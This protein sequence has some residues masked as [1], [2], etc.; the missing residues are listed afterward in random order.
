M[1]EQ[2]IPDMAFTRTIAREKSKI[3]NGSGKSTR[4]EVYAAW[5]FSQRLDGKNFSGDMP[6]RKSARKE[7]YKTMFRL[8]ING[9]WYRPGGR[10]YVFLTL[11]EIAKMLLQYSGE[12]EC[13]E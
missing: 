6:A 11:A 8:R 9:R 5:Q 3:Q 2:R 13:G 12:N 4:F 10:K 1:S 7:F